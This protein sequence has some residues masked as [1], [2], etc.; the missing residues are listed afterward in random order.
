[1]K[2]TCLLFTACLLFLAATAN[3]I[4]W[5]RNVTISQPVNEDLYI[6][7]GTITINAPIHGDLIV[8][9][10]T[11]HINDTVMNDL[12]LV[13]GTV[14]S[15]GFVADDVR[16]AGGRL[17]IVKSIGGDLVITGGKV[18]IAS[19]VFIGGGLVTGGGEIT[20]NGTING[21]VRSAAG[22]FTFNGTANRNFDCR[23]QQLI[24][25][26]VVKGQSVLAGGV[27]TIGERASFYND[28]RFWNARRQLDVGNSV[29]NGKVTYDK[30][31]KVNPNA[32]YYLG[33]STMLGLIWYLSTVLLFLILI[34]YLF[35]NIFKKAGDSMGEAMGKSFGMGVL[36]LLGVPLAIMLLLITVIGIPVGL[37]IMFSYIVILLLATSI[38]SL[39][40]ANWYN[41][42]FQRNWTYWQ[43]V[44]SG[45]A[46]FILFKLVTST[47]LFG[48]PI[49]ITIACIAFGSI[50]RN[51]NWIRKPQLAI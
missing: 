49:M 35:R 23:S 17:E 27:I 39:V 1:M 43:I 9:G 40:V 3:R 2:K 4:E 21:D 29:R 11:I 8:A 13:G 5:G 15:N 22:S 24:M 38:S 31:L 50:L 25:N 45:L 19:N 20:V 18:D 16:C 14:Y 51:I 28:I 10:G 26:G 41:H 33:Q 36:F 37:I 32:W 46:M 44:F 6:A 34:Q 48:W 42:R 30:T 7:G 12:L 47:P